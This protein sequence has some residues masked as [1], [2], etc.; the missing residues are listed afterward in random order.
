MSHVVKN[1]LDLGGAL[2]GYP[3]CVQKMLIETG[4]AGCQYIF[5]EFLP[6]MPKVTLTSYI[7]TCNEKFPIEKEKDWSKIEALQVELGEVGQSRD[8]LGK[9]GKSSKNDLEVAQ[10]T[11]DAKKE[12]MSSLLE[13]KISEK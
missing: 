11:F 5:V 1:F 4:P 7:F 2:L 10:Q 8:D 13:N 9:Q 6:Y 12:E 3:L